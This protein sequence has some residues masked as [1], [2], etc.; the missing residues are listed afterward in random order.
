MPLS[1]LLHLLAPLVTSCRGFQE[2]WNSAPAVPPGDPLT[3]RWHGDWHSDAN[4]FQGPLRAVMVRLD[5]HRWRATF[6][7]TFAK[8]LK[9]CYSTDLVVDVGSL[10]FKG[11]SDLG[12]FGGGVYDYAGEVAGDLFTSTFRS[13]TD[14]GTF[15]MRRV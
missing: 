1:D 6:H 8:V 12:T 9:A 10:T 2:A 13:R 11:S 3:G 14:H 4:G 15:R 7:A 5:E